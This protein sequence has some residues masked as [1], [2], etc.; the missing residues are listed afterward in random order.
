MPENADAYDTLAIALECLN[1]V[2]EQKEVKAKA[3][4]IFEKEMKIRN[5]LERRVVCLIKMICP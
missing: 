5:I 3:D 1:E 2:D 4:K